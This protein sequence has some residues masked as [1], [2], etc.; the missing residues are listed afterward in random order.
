[1]VKHAQQCETGLSLHFIQ[2]QSSSSPATLQKVSRSSRSHAIR[3]GLRKKR[4]LEQESGQ[5]F[6]AAKIIQTL[7]TT[8]SL[9]ERAPGPARWSPV[10]PAVPLWGVEPSHGLDLLAG[11]ASKLRGWL[12]SSR[13]LLSSQNPDTSHLLNSL[14][15][16]QKYRL[17]RQRR[18]R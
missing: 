3:T 2:A 8:V 11:D 18:P 14:M 12:Q 7:A 16:T 13:S 15:L 10:T 6:R 17:V 4:R 9:P 5:N 1:M